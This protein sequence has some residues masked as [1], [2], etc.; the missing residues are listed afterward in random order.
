[1]IA[2]AVREA[3]VEL[4]GDRV[5]FDVPLSRHTALRIGGPA[6]AVA[7]PADRDELLR[8]LR[9]CARAGL[10]HTVLGSGF[11]TLVLDGGVAG[12]VLRLVRLRGLEAKP[13]GA[14]RIEAGVSHATLTNYCI[15]N[16][17]TGLEFGAG[18][19]GTVGGWTFMNAGIGSREMKDVLV[20]AEVA[21]RDGAQLETLR[22][23]ELRP[24]YR[25]LAGLPDASVIVSVVVRVEAA[26]PDVVRAEVERLRARRAATQPLDLPS[27]GSVF[28]NPPGDFAGR[29]IEAAGQ[30]GARVG[31]A[32]ISPVHANFIVNHGGARAADVLAL[33]ERARSAVLERFGVALEPEVRVIGRSA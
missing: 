22:A 24:C 8:C 26:D 21:S 15:R 4:L 19:P 20:E 9:L 7:E 18:I 23:A 17:L 29:L 3:L 11:N 1:V 30:K 33:V 14:L 12:L 28:K 10:R 16:G 31:A 32:E 5:A 2:P 13:E 27:C 6:D 25:V